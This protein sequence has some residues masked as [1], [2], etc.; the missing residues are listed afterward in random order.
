M[1][2]GDF[3]LNKKVVEEINEKFS[4]MN[5][6]ELEII[7]LS[8]LCMAFIADMTCEILASDTVQEKIKDNSV[9]ANFHLNVIAGAA[10]TSC[11]RLI[12]RTNNPENVING[13]KHHFELAM[14]N[15]LKVIK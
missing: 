4:K 8:T 14:I 3:I 15:I 1:K 9:L 2:I 7:K 13:F 10:A 6:E 5:P 12:S 11:F